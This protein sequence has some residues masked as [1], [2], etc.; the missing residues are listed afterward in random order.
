MDPGQV[1]TEASRA[2][3]KCLEIFVQCFPGGMR[4]K[5]PVGINCPCHPDSVAQSSAVQTISQSIGSSMSNQS[6]LPGFHYRVDY[7]RVPPADPSKFEYSAP[8]AWVAEH[9]P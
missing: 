6:C 4:Q 2:L 7:P 5:V 3:P 8:T 9:Y 1:E